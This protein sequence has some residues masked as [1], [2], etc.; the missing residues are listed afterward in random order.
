MRQGSPGPAGFVKIGTTQFLY[1]DQLG[2]TQVVDLD[3][4]QKP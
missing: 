3:V 2:K 4:Y 1:R